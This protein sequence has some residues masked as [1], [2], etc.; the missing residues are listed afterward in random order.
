MNSSNKDKEYINHTPELMQLMGQVGERRMFGGHGLFLQGLVFCLVANQVLYLKVDNTTRSSF[1]ARN[2]EPF[3]YQRQGKPCQL[4]YYQAPD[5][6]FEY[7]EQ[8]RT[9]AVTA[10]NVAQHAAMEK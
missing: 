10:F 6:V 7:P 2:L 1:T 9:W 3:T 5:E 4:A 8:I